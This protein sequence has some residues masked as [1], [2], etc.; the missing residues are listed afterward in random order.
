MSAA[1][2]RRGFLALVGA[3]A[4]TGPV[5]FRKAI[6]NPTL[7]LPPSTALVDVPGI[8]P[9]LTAGVTHAEYPL[10]SHYASEMSAI[11]RI[12]RDT[13][14]DTFRNWLEVGLHAAK[15]QAPQRAAAMD[16]ALAEHGSIVEALRAGA[17]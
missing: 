10:L 4:V 11:C 15:A 16:R 5:L 8:V 13:T 2:P 7:I 6:A 9:G 14:D 12:K 3:A 17:L 1:S